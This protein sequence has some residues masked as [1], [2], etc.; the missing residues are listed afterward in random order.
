VIQL[1]RRHRGIPGRSADR[2]VIDRGTFG[3]EESRT[4]THQTEGCVH[5]PPRDSEVVGVL[6][7]QL[8]LLGR[9]LRAYC[10]Q[11]RDEI[12]NKLIKIIKRE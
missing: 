11:R 10:G 6:E 1:Q 5:A 9:G 2:E 8:E 7:L 4:Q 12:R 3:L